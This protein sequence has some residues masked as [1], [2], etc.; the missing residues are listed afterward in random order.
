MMKEDKKKR[1]MTSMGKAPSIDDF[2]RGSKS[3]LGGLS[4]KS[5]GSLGSLGAGGSK[6]SMKSQRGNLLGEIPGLPGRQDGGMSP[7]TSQFYG[8]GKEGVHYE[9]DGEDDGHSP[10]PG[11]GVYS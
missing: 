1:S 11:E 2:N 10:L 6:A 3:S 5:R 4:Q 7:L 8:T 9:E